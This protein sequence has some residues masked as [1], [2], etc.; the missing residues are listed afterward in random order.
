MRQGFEFNN[1]EWEDPGC[2]FKLQFCW[3]YRLV[4]CWDIEDL[5]VEEAYDTD[6]ESESVLE[7]HR[8]GGV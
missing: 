2:L 6:L 7:E 3:G 8:K 1:M 4:C 5:S